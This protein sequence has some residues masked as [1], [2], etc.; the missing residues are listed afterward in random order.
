[1]TA[2][3]IPLP[4]SMPA[5]SAQNMDAGKYIAIVD[6]D[7]PL[8][9]ALARLIRACSF[10]VQT[11]CSGRDF[12]DSLATGAP[13][14]LILDLQ[15]LEMTGLEV[16]QQLAEMGLRI[17]TIFLTA[18]DEPSAR[19]SCDMVGASSFLVKPVMRDL[20]LESINSAIAPQS[21]LRL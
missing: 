5:T 13:D 4:Q 6:D 7:E 9:R 10:R 18:R 19:S 16:A 1:M 14:C 8:R 12:I 21:A 20:L 15:M 3:L 11:Y 2:K 17:P